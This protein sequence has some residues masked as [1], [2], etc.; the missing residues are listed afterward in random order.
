MPT[1]SV[2][3]MKIERSEEEGKGTG[4]PA[5][6]QWVLLL[7]TEGFAAT[8]VSENYNAKIFATQISAQLLYNSVKIIDQSDID[9]LELL[10]RRKR[11]K[12]VL[13]QLG[14]EVV[15]SVKVLLFLFFCSVKVQLLLLVPELLKLIFG[16]LGRW[17]LAGRLAIHLVTA[18]QTRT[19]HT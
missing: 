15:L 2:V 16:Q 8:N 10:G 4:K 18:C 12:K 7:D 19:V 11:L 6:P 17:G 9:Y 13:L 1:D 14:V 3:P 5:G